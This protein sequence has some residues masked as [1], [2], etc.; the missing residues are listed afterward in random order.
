VAFAEAMGMAETPDS[1]VLRRV[2]ET[3]PRAGARVAINISGVSMQSATF[4]ARLLD[5]VARRP[6]L[7]GR[8]MAELTETADIENVAAA[9]DTV[10]RLDA[11]GVSARSMARS[12]AMRR[13]A[14]ATA[15]L[16][17]PCCCA[18]SV[19]ARSPKRSR[20]SSRRRP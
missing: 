13:V 9:V 4:R 12:C 6:A 1:A 14:R 10:T 2:V 16:S 8:L 5:Q 3:L 11:A 19:R 17:A 7:G 18:A 20:L 15:D